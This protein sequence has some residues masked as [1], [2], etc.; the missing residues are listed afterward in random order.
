ML[1]AC[2]SFIHRFFFRHT[3]CLFLFCFTFFVYEKLYTTF[4]FKSIINWIR[5]HNLFNYCFVEFFP[6]FPAIFSVELIEPIK[7]NIEIFSLLILDYYYFHTTTRSCFLAS[8]LLPS[9]SILVSFCPM[10]FFSFPLSHY[11]VL[12]YHFHTRNS[13]MSPRNRFGCHFSTV[14]RHPGGLDPFQLLFSSKLKQ[15][16]PNECE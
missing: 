4:F 1:I 12:S 11:F 13:K 3:F 7:I 14:G 16:N 5:D 2:Q 9:T 10:H 8:F 15:F 6:L